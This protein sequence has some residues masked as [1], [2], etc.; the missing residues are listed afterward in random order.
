MKYASS[1][2]AGRLQTEV[3]DHRDI[4]YDD[5]GLDPGYSNPRRSVSCGDARSS[6]IETLT[7]VAAENA[8]RDSSGH[9]RLQA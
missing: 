5:G 9:F 7:R 4:F 2:M 8:A 3:L 6:Q 1:G